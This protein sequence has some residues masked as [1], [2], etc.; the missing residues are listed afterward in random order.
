MIGSIMDKKCRICPRQ[1][2]VN[3]DIQVGAC[4]MSN[5]VRIALTMLHKWEE[6]IISG[7]NGSGTVFFSGCNLKCNYCQNYDVSHRGKGYDI[8]DYELAECFKRLEAEGAHNINLVT[9]NHYVENIINALNIYRPNIPICYNT[10]GYDSTE[11]I[12]RLIP[13]VDI[14]LTDF[15][16]GDADLARELSG[17][18]DYVSVASEAVKLMREVKPDIIVDG[19]MKQGIIIRH[20]VLPTEIKNSIKVIEWLA[21]NMPRDTVVSL[22]SQFTPNVGKSRLSRGIKPIE[23]KILCER[24]LKAGFENAYIQE[25]DSNSDEYIPEFKGECLY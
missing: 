10:S 14:F 12:R 17:A 2:G 16:Y 22:M 8:S 4:G 20:L 9:P 1:C 3:R 5:T 21:D 24:L 11:T 13:Y 25:P 23:Y 15:K 19:L 6:P 18:A 7:V